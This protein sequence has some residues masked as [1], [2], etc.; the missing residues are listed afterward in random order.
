MFMPYHHA[1]S[2]WHFGTAIGVFLF[3]LPLVGFGGVALQA[4][5]DKRSGPLTWMGLGFVAAGA[6]FAWWAWRGWLA[7]RRLADSPNG[8]SSRYG[9]H[10]DGGE[11]RA[12]KYHPDGDQ[13]IRF[14][15]G[16]VERI[17]LGPHGNNP[18][19]TKVC[20]RDGR[21]IWLTTRLLSGEDM[22]RLTQLL[23]AS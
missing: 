5:I 18:G 16:D 17:Q 14:R 13:E 4:A 7:A 6:G 11:V 9:I 3:S 19:C 22:H 10:V 20:M 1:S 2:K 12:L 21:T 8:P 15:L 23:G